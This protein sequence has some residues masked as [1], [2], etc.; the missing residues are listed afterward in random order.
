MSMPESPEPAVVIAC[1]PTAVPAEEREQWIAAGKQ[2]Y[3][4]VQDMQ[5]LPKGYA[6][7]LAPDS[8]ML[9]TLAQ[10]VANERLCCPFLQFTIEIGAQGSPFRLHL[11]GG[12]GV[13]EYIRSV[14]AATTLLNERVMRV[15]DLL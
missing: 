11:T 4:S 8:A 13:K 10:Y 12:T 5:E 15:A 7:T 9:L 14:F 3:A 2:V 6:F 1:D